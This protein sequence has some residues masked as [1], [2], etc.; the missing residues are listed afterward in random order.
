MKYLLIITL[1]FFLFTSGSIAQAQNADTLYLKSNFWGNKFYKGDTIYSINGVLE[2]LAANEQPYNLMLK[3]KKDN[4]FAQIFGAA[5]G[6]LI[7]WSVVTDLSG[8]EPNWYLVGIGVGLAVISI[9]LS[10]NFKKKANQAL[11][12]HNS[13]ITGS[14]KWDYKP[15]Y[16]FG[17][18][19]NGLQLRIRF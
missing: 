13:L 15:V 12:Q 9:P 14:N 18:S 2:E 11:Q 8:G 3:A 1:T 16:H 5:G 7:G 19:G 10:I 4:T 6:L 17:L